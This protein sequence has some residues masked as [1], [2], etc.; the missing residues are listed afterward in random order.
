MLPKIILCPIIGQP[1]GYSPA[2]FSSA[3]KIDR[4]NPH[5]VP[6]LTNNRASG[7]LKERG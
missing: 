4:Q 7:S 5:P 1:H 2:G 3:G 6:R